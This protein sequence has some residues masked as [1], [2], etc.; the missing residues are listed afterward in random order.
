[1]KINDATGQQL[2]F[3]A[4]MRCRRCRR[5]LNGKR[6]RAR[7]YGRDCWKKENEPSVSLEQGTDDDQHNSNDQAES[8]A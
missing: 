4:D 5:K 2:L 3:D 1:M 6:S 7:G 8:P